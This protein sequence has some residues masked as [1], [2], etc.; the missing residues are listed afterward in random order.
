VE[1]LDVVQPPETFL[2]GRNS[3]PSLD[4]PDDELLIESVNEVG[5]IEAYVSKL[6]E[7][8]RTA[9]ELHCVKKHTYP[10]IASE[11]N[12]SRGTVKSHI[13][14]GMK[15]LREL[16]KRK[17]AGLDLIGEP[18]AESVEDFAKILARL[19]GLAE[20]YRTAVELHYVKKQTYPQMASQLN[21]S[22]GTVKSHVSRGMKM[23]RL[24]V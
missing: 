11:L 13:S 2:A 19:V 4:Q 1:R 17:D 22:K 15:M 5:E 20:P 10:Q 7:P 12:L 24:L 16:L 6:R 18:E 9:V 23:L 21:L 14:R 8:Y 3:L